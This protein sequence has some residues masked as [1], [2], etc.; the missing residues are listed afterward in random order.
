M[1]KA[2]DKDKPAWKNS[3]GWLLISLVTVVM[4]SLM[5]P[6]PISFIVSLIIIIS[7]NVI[8]ADIAL[9]KAGM[10]GIKGWYRSYSSLQSGRGWNT[11]MNNSLYSPSKIHLYELW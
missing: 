10:G 5:L 2:E 8:R 3:L 4:V 11:D 1:S 7:F 6:F 9:K